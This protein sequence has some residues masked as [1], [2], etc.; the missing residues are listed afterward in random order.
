MHMLMFS[1]MYSH[2]PNA[3]AVAEEEAGELEWVFQTLI[4]VPLVWLI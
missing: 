2:M 4:T 1:T 3:P